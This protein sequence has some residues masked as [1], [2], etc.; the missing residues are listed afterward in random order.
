[1]LNDHWPH[2]HVQAKCLAFAARQRRNDLLP[3]YLMITKFRQYTGEILPN[4]MGALQCSQLLLMDNRNGS[5]LK[6][7]SLLATDDTKE[8]VIHVLA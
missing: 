6:E 3:G 4:R 7:V 5:S 2:I 8:K 1:M